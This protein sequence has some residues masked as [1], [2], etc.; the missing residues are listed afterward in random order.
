MED[1]AKTKDQLK[2]LLF[3]VK[4]NENANIDADIYLQIYS[5]KETERDSKKVYMMALCDQ[6]YKFNSFFLA[7]NE[8]VPDLKEGKIIHLTEVSP[9][10]IKNSTFIRIKEYSILG[11]PLEIPEVKEVKMEDFENSQPKEMEIE[12]KDTK[13]EETSKPL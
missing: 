6:E 12:K 5:V 8:G 9:K 1:Y 10:K 7:T 13:T 2:T 11:E 3:L 4:N